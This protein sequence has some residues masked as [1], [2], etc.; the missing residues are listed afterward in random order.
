M[1]QTQDTEFLARCSMEKLVQFHE[2]GEAGIGNGLIYCRLFIYF[3]Q[4]GNLQVASI[5]E[6]TVY[7]LLLW[8][9]RRQRRSETA[10]V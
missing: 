2:H 6:K 7:C 3:S 1:L 8:F 9:G 5:K 4:E 10:I